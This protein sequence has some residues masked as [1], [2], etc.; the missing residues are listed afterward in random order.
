M[1][2][3]HLFLLV[4]VSALSCAPDKETTV[5]PSETNR[6][7]IEEMY[8]ELI[9]KLHL[10]V[11]SLEKHVAKMR[12]LATNETPKSKVM[13]AIGSGILFSNRSKYQLALK[14]YES[15]L[16]LLPKEA[17]TLRARVFAGI[18]NVHKNQGNYPK[19][20]QYL[21]KALAIFQKSNNAVGSAGTHGNIAQVYLQKGDMES[22]KKQLKISMQLLDNKRNHNAYLSSAHT[23]ANVHG[24]SGEYDEA[25]KIDDLGIALAD[26]LKSDRIMVTF[27]DNKANCFM[28]TN[29]LDSAEYYFKACLKLDEKIGDSKQIADSYSN[30]GNLYMLKKNYPKALEL[31][32]HSIKLLRDIDHKPN[33]LKSYQVLGDIY[34]SAGDFKN[35]FAAQ[36]M[37]LET[38]R[39]LMNEKKELALAEFQILHETQQKEHIIAQGKIDLL[40]KQRE[41]KSRNDLIFVISLFAFFIALTGFM[42]YRQQR[43]RN[44]QLLQEHELKDAMLQ[45]ESQNRLQQQRLGISRDLHDNIGAQ[46][47]FIISSVDAL[48]Y[49]FN[50]QNPALEAKLQNINSFTKATIVELR[51]TIWAMNQN[52]IAL[53]ELRS[54]IYNFIGNAKEACVAIDFQFYIDNDLQA[55]KVTSVMGMNIYR[56]VQEAINNAIKYANATRIGVYFEDSAHGFSIRIEDDGN[57]FDLNSIQ[58]GNGLQNM[59]KRIESVGGKYDLVSEPGKGT[60]IFILFKDF[61]QM[62]S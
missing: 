49:A 61:I 30:M 31:T 17:D 35:A 44:R 57:G 60:H 23:L 34:E 8:N 37:Y 45:I 52:E 58:L 42:I 53:E 59:K 11:D 6:Q 14:E 4:V 18:G 21:F 27:L 41:V 54:R 40:E 12:S 36:K 5:L 24:A 50:I 22:A 20:N 1:T 15:A 16:K 9:P 25:L 7:Q 51:D 32:N 47:T 13:V 62:A 26:S 39:D 29:R 46:L 33:L 2:K 55:F 38:Y 28:Y 56:T 43:I 48:R 10:S 19:A 3:I